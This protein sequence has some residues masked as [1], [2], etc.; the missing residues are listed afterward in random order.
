MNEPQTS[1]H[2]IAALSVH[3]FTAAGAFCAFMALA[4]VLEGFLGAAFGWLGLALVIDGLDGP[5]ARLVDVETN[6]PHWNGAILDLV[7]D[8]LNYVLVPL[9]A[10]WRAGLLPDEIAT[11]LCGVLAALSALYF[12]DN[13]MKTHDN[14]FRGFPALWNVLALYLFCFP[15]A[16]AFNAGVLVVFGALMFAPVVFVHPVRVERWRA[17]TLVVTAV[18]LGAAFWALSIGFGPAPAPRALLLLTGLYFLTLAGWRSLFA[19]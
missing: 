3:L 7:V 13:R 10:V 18:W 2:Q 12:A 15:L 16:P 14:W 8:Y 5:L 1:R 11:L 17:L 4:A 19:R 9:V 6:A